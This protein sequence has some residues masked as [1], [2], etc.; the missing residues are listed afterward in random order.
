M[1][2]A[3]CKLCP[4]LCQKK[5]QAPQKIADQIVL[6]NANLHYLKSEVAKQNIIQRYLK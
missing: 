4:R 1:Q 3:K 6:E 5:R 2:N